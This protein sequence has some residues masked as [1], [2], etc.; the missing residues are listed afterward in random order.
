MSR[1]TK[2]VAT[3]GPA[4]NTPE[5]LEAMIRAGVN[6]VR[7]NFS[8]GT[9]EDHMARAQMVRDA[10][11]RIGQPIGI[12]G[13]LQG[14]KIRVGKFENGK[15]TLET[16]DKFILDARCTMG[17][18]ER[19]GLDYKDLPKDVTAGAVLLLARGRELRCPEG[20]AFVGALA[21]VEGRRLLYCEEVRGRPRPAACLS[22]RCPAHPAPDSR[23]AA[24]R[25]PF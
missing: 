23:L 16:G 15:I 14:P 21:S 8:H 17:N 18:Q 25:F 6:V 10:A 9:P 11:A 3:L 20:Q 13:D 24:K 7:M 19:V 1:H 2:I 12:L 4:S 22:L 5:I